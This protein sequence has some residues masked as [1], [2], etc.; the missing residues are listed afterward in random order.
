MREVFVGLLL[1]CAIEGLLLAGFPEGMRKAM[2]ETS[3]VPA[4]YLRLAGLVFA[5]VGVGGLW[6]LRQ[7]GT[8]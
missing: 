6:L 8:L 7:L 2:E 5:L 3:K 1:V 4:R